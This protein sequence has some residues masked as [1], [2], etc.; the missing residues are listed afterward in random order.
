[1][2]RLLSTTIA[3]LLT[4]WVWVTG[5]LI[6]PHFASDALAAPQ[7]EERLDRAYEEFGQGAGLQEEIFQERV[8]QGENP[9]D[10][11]KPYKRIKNFEG[12][13]VPPTSLLE[14]T[15]SKAQDLVEKVTGK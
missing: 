10:L 6:L 9:E 2:K 1:M 14:K 5:S 11:P 7:Q 8:Q 3:L 15:V 4:V 13:E 12:K